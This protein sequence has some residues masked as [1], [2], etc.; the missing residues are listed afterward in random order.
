MSEKTEVTAKLSE[1]LSVLAGDTVEDRV[2]GILRMVLEIDEDY[3][4][5]NGRITR[6]LQRLNDELVEKQNLLQI[7]IQRTLEDLRQQFAQKV[8]ERIAAVSSDQIAEA[9]AKK[10]LVT[11]PATHDEIRRGADGVLVVRQ[12]TQTE[13][14]QQKS[15]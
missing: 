14:H 12:A 9:L 3:A 13:L 15:Q 6:E 10:I 7:E 11:R 4:A 5:L 2:Q 8:Q 1:Q